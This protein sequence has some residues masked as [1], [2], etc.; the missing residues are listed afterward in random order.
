MARRRRHYFRKRHSAPE[1]KKKPVSTASKATYI[2]SLISLVVFLA[3]IIVAVLMDG[4]YIKIFVG[5]GFCFLLVGIYLLVRSIMRAK[6]DEEPLGA[7]IFSIVTS[8]LS[9]VPW[10]ALYVIGMING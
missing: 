4:Q 8:A 1:K 3:G 2:V 9:L 5:L 10:M 7:R 6:S